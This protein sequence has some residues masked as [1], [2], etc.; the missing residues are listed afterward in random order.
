MSHGGGVNVCSSHS[1]SVNRMERF[2]HRLVATSSSNLI[3]AICL[4]LLLYINLTTSA[5]LDS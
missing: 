5:V 2:T 3:V 4:F 1:R